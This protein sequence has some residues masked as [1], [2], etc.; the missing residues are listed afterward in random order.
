VITTNYPGRSTPVLPLPAA[1][2]DPAHGA[3]VFAARCASCHGADGLGTKAEGGYAFPP[4]WG[5][6]SYNDGAGMARP[7]TAANFI[8]ANM[9]FG[10]SY[11]APVLSEQEAFDV[12]VFIDSQP[13]PHRA[14]NEADYPNLALKPADAL[15]PPFVGPFSAEQHRI[16]PWGPIRD[17]I[18]ANGASIPATR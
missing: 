10:T 7:V 5:P 4:L 15:Y 1:A 6:D 9:P 14:G 12:A 13:R 16:G 2:A 17:W 8:R 18:K 3:A 11:E